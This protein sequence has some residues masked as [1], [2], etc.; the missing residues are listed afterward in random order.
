MSEWVR[1]VRVQ[2][3]AMSIASI[4]GYLSFLVEKASGISS[5][6]PSLPYTVLYHLSKNPV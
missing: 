2:I 3:E 4:L 6:D 5:S 1:Y